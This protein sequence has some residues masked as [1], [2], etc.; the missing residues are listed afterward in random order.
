VTAAAG[1]AVKMECDLR[2]AD[3]TRMMDI[4]DLTVSVPN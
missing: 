4:P 2:A 3:M 1:H